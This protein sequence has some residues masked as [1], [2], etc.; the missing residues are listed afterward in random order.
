MEKTADQFHQG[1]SALSREAGYRQ[2]AQAFAG[3]YRDF[4]REQPVRTVLA[5]I[6]ELLV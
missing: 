6:E 5:A 1:L 3:K 2:A 4:D